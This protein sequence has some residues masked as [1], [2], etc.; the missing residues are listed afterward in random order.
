V[1][2]HDRDDLRVL[3]A[4][5]VGHGTRVHPLQRVQAGGV[6]AEQDAVDQI[7]GLLA[8]QCL[9]QHVADVVVRPDTERGLGAQ[10]AAEL[11][12]HALDLL[13]GDIGHRR[14]RDTDLL[15]F[16]GFH[17]AQHFG[18]VQFAQRQ[19]QHGGALHTGQGR[20]VSH[21]PPSP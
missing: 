14:H 13:T 10:F 21:W 20:G 2:H 18:C 1:R 3:V 11:V 9:H 5:Q 19:Q 15:H 12:H 6:A 17:V 7:A 8:A 16:L 4:H